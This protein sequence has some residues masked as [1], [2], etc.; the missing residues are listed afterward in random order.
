[1]KKTRRM[2]ILFMIISIISL[3]IYLSNRPSPGME[4]KGNEGSITIISLITAI[5]SLCSTIVTLIKQII[6]LKHKKA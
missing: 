2:M 3:L 6:E 4:I 5:V 1:M